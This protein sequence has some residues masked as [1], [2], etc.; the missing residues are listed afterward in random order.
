MKYHL[1]RAAL[2]ASM[3]ITASAAASA[4]DQAGP[5]ELEEVLVFG[6]LSNY[7]AM[8]SEVPILETAR[9]ISI[10]TEQQLIDKGVLSLDQA[11]TYSAGVFG[12]TFGYA[13]RGD[14]VRVRGLEVPQYRD[15]L[16]AL[17]G[18]YN[19][20]RPD[21]FTLEQVEILKGPAS[22]LYGQGSPGG[23][24]NVVSKRPKSE[25]RHTFGA[26]AGSFSR[27]QF[28]LDS[29]GPLTEDGTWLYRMVALYRDSETQID[30]IDDE[31]LV[32]APSISYRPSQDTDLTLLLNY[33]DNETD[34]AAQ[35]LPIAGTLEP[36]PNGQRIDNNAYFGEPTFNRFDTETTALTL[37][38]SHRFNQTW[39][40]ELT[41]RYTDGSADYQQAWPSFILGDRYVRNLDGSL[42]Q[43]G[44]VPRSFFRSDATSEQIAFDA[45][46][47]ANFDTGS[48]QHRVMLGGQ[49]Q[50]VTLTDAGYY[51]YALGYAFQPGEPTTPLGDT[52]WI[53]LF[54]PQYGNVPP[55]ELLDALYAESPDSEA[56]DLGLYIHD[57]MT[58]GS[59]HL[60]LGL[61]YDETETT[62]ASESQD[63][64]AISVSAGLLYEFDNGL[65][66]YVN[67]AESFD[68]V[69]GDNGAGQA[70]EPREG[71]QL[72]IGLKYQPVNFPA[73]VTLAWFDI[74]QTN[75]NDP[76]SRPGQLQQQSGKA[77]VEGVELEAQATLGDFQLEFNASHLETENVDGF[78]F[79]SVPEDQA[80]AWVS[81]RP[82]GA[83]SGLRVGGGV[84]YVG[85]SYGGFDNLRTPSYTL[86][87][88]ML[89][90]GAGPWDVQLN[91]RNIT[92][93][94][95]IATCIAR[96]DCYVGRERTVVARLQ[97]TF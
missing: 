89:G 14:W 33:T 29:T 78:R 92:D 59:L 6:T 10:E 87:D 95:Y 23:I 84:R 52:Y 41:S 82:K 40:M 31:S 65:A 47:R 74:E 21:I 55:D 35:F 32:L 60:T 80:S 77:N 96:G 91:V 62:V 64:D 88:V 24:V 11:Y 83:F 7:G 2:C 39:S 53:N 46:F 72:E 69:I 50:D 67:Y 38:A 1:G 42:Y 63:D 45:R 85:D 27:G 71:E 28:T 9:S 94:D 58:L 97:Y 36:A 18:N 76:Q 16:Q 17:F 13:T 68:P 43:D 37:L 70:L 81:W 93:K 15:S 48:L 51:A 56:E 44:T 5:V 73:L 12:E 19:N 90:W 4:Q 8:K 49:Y 61:R 34:S 54:N 66:P 26:E 57:H 20:T 79:A 30:E 25:A 3:L 86:G 22:V 75:L